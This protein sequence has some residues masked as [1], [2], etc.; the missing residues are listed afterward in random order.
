MISAT[1]IPGMLVVVRTLITFAVF[2]YLPGRIASRG[3][4]RT[5]QKDGAAQVI[6]SI[7]ISMLMLAFYFTN[8]IYTIF[9]S[10][11]SLKSILRGISIGIIKIR[12][13][14]LPY[15]VVCLVFY[16]MIKAGR[17]FTFTYS[18]L[19][20]GV[21]LLLLVSAARYYFSTL[22]AEIGKL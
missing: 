15:S 16:V 10:S 21:L 5:V 20:L 18:D 14:L 3:Q 8:S 2:L 12:M 4:I 17:S 11:M 22:T 6:E 9:M 1:D 7:V 13:F 19:V